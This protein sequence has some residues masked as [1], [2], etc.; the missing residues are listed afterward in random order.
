MKRIALG[1]LLAIALVS[2]FAGGRTAETQLLA[3]IE[4]G[5]RGACSVAMTDGAAWVSVY[6]T[7]EVVRVDPAT[8]E[9]VA[10]VPVRGGPCGIVA[11]EGAVWVENFNG[12][13]VQPIDPAQNR[14]VAGVGVGSRTYDVAYGHGSIWVTNNASRTV[15]RVDPRRNR[16]V[17]TIR[18]PRLAPRGGSITAE[19]LWGGGGPRGPPPG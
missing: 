15:S 18:H 4:V 8:N 1:S 9:V 6:N 16:L 11:A 14:V 13:S 7:N 3:R 19:P 12:S 17:K 2:G 5:G 10:R